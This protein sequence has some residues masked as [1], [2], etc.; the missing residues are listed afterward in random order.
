VE[1]NIDRIGPTRRESCTRRQSGRQTWR[2]LLFLH[3][4]VPVEELRPL[5]PPALSIDTFAGRAFV[6][7]VP[8]TMHAVRVGPLPFRDFL[9]TNVR[10]Y[11]HAQGVP[12]VWFLSLDAEDRL[13]VWGGRTLYRLPYFRAQMRCQAGDGAV[14]YSLRRVE[15][16]AALEVRWS[17]LERQPHLAAPDTLEHFLTERYALYGRG[18]RGVYRVRVH[19]RPWPLRRARV[20]RLDT[21]LLVAAGLHPV[22]APIDLALE[23][24]DGVEVEV[25]A[26]EPV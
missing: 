7:L 20:D 4:E 12:G 3:W 16:D 5:V 1:T 19:H 24:A 2:E 9:E 18:A 13:A 25:F 10:T 23:S 17:A 11:V 26:R 6:G 15:G 22:G 8:F 14:D 21:S